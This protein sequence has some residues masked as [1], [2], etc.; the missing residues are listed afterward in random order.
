MN[1]PHAIVI[2]YNGSSIDEAA[3]EQILGAIAKHV[4]D[5]ASQAMI[6]LFN[7]DDL[8]KEIIRTCMPP[9]QSTEDG[10]QAAKVIMGMLPV[11]CT[12][13]KI[14]CC[15]ALTKMLAKAEF[16]HD[17]KSNAFLNAMSIISQGNPVSTKVCNEW[18]F[19]RMIREAVKETYKLFINE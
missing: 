17:A 10:D 16:E 18:K 13:N 4:T 3:I 7:E 9:A 15:V 11:D 8:A 5:G 14:K 6:K 2:F 19:T 12:D 1:K